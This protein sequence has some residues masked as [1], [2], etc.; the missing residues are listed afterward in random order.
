MVNYAA[1]Q[2]DLVHVD[3][4]ISSVAKD[5][6]DSLKNKLK[7]VPTQLQFAL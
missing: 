7:A 5:V 1:T 3:I 6:A 2:A 4:M